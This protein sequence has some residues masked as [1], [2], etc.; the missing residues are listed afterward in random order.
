MSRTKD[1]SDPQH[2]IEFIQSIRDGNVI[3]VIALP[4]SSFRVIWVPIKKY[5]ADGVEYTDE[6]WTTEDGRM[7]NCQD[8]E[9][10][11]AKNIIR[12]TL[13]NERKYRQQEREYLEA[14]HN[15]AVKSLSVNTNEPKDA[16]T[17]NFPEWIATAPDS[18]YRLH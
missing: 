4:D 7:I 13:R 17:D 3:D 2:A 9:P 11:H 12:M 10:E 18:N 14:L 16:D 15:T 5:I 8:L 1:F 6:V